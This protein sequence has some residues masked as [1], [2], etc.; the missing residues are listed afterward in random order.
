MGFKLKLD[1]QNL[2]DYDVTKI[3]HATIEIP[4][5]A[6]SPILLIS[7]TSYRKAMKLVS[8]CPGR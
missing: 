5:L 2:A 7:K 4:T 6:F 3:Q 8:K 1:T